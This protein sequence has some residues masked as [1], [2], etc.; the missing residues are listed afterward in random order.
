MKK[1]GL[2]C[3]V[4]A[5]LLVCLSLCFGCGD[6]PA[7]PKPPEQPLTKGDVCTQMNIARMPDK[8]EYSPGEYFD[9]SGLVFDAVYENGYNGDT[10]LTADELDGWSPFGTLDADDKSVT[11]RYKGIE[12]KIDISIIKRTFTG[13]SITREPYIKT[14]TPGAEFRLDGLVVTAVYDD[15]SSS[16]I[17]DY[18]ITDAD[19]KTYTN[20]TRLPDEA[21]EITLTVSVTVDGKTTTAPLTVRVNSG[22]SISVEA[23]AFVAGATPT[24][25]SYT[26]LT[27]K[28]GTEAAKYTDNSLTGITCV[29]DFE[30]G[31]KIDFYVYSE[32]AINGAMLVLTASSLDRGDGE[33]FDSRFN[34]IFSV[35]VD[36][37]SVPVSSAA[38]IAGRKAASN[39]KIWFLWTDNE[40]ASVNLKAGY[41]KITLE[42]IG[43]ITDRADKS[44]RA[45]NVDKI[46]IKF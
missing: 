17:T 37:T 31:S 25:E 21:G 35:S 24:D 40:I 42:C 10:G 11:L 20:G 41:T 29:K 12:K 2:F 15:G 26:V 39:E 45:S 7:A 28:G 30:P 8:I 32:R 6:Q 46:S 13:M 44:K 27:G 43:K 22:N 1:K 36:D 9:P 4:T 14:Y 33:T 34:D 5:I 23:E 3:A 38:V 16:A 18:T 19:G